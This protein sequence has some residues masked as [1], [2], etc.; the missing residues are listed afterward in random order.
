[1]GE[2]H[3]LRDGRRQ[4][5]RVRRSRERAQSSCCADGAPAGDADGEH[6]LQRGSTDGGDGSND[7]GSERDGGELG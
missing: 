7:E 1:V 4:V 3:R 2:L 5:E 6:E